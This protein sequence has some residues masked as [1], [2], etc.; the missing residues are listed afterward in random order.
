[1]Q[2][3]ESARLDANWL[4]PLEAFFTVGEESSEEK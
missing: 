4:T 2:G 1:V 3:L